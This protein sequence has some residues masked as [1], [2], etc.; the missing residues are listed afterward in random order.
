M[1]SSP[2]VSSQS[3]RKSLC[4]PK[5]PIRPLRTNW[6]PTI[7]AN[8]PTSRSPNHQN[9]V[10]S[11]LTSPSVT[12]LVLWVLLLWVYPIIFRTIVHIFVS[13]SATWR[14]L[15]ALRYPTTS[16]DGWKR[17]RTLWTTLSL[18]S[19]R[20][21]LTSSCAKSSL[22]TLDSLA[23]LLMPVAR[24]SVEFEIREREEK[25]TLKCL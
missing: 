12:T 21:V 24:V 19:T 7:S 22:I 18:T 11:L 3:L 25:V 13:G 5:P 15:F 6:T 9:Q 4:S 8:L 2:W 10:A 23:V 17:T 14:Y 1:Y 16:Q 20:R